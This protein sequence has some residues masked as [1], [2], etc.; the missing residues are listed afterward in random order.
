[1]PPKKRKDPLEIRGKI[2]PIRV[3]Q[4]ELN[5]ISEQASRFGLSSSNYLRSLGMNYPVK[6]I[7]DEQAAAALLKTNSDL[8][9]LG[10]LFKMWLN[11]N[12]DD[13]EN[14]SSQRTYKDID[15]LVDEIERIQQILKQE[16]LKIM[17][18][19]DR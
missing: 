19:N 2:L 3:N 18:S 7:V 12:S 10:G 5:S 8:G 11:R 1:M 14:F 17:R 9:R 15:V 6:S 16:A 4:E 13:K